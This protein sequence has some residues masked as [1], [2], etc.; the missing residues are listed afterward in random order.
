MKTVYFDSTILSYLYDSR[1]EMEFL[2]RATKEWWAT[3]RT[4]FSCF[5]SAETLRELGEGEY[6]RKDLIL[7]EA[8]K[9]SSLP[10]NK[11][12]VDTA[13]FYIQNYLMPKEEGGDALH[14]A[15]ASH[16]KI[17]YLL[18]WNY[19]HLVNENKRRHIRILND[20]LKLTTPI[21][22]APIELRFGG[23]EE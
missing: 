12:I 4:H 11:D 21:I 5:L 13:R 22:I 16:H 20:K 23:G 3:E 2:I 6:P 1:S 10:I 18:S 8:L 7:Q 19:S 9:I 15:V 17:D 14:L